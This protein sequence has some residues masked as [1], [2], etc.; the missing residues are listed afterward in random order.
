VLVRGE[1]VQDLLARDTG[2]ST[3]FTHADNDRRNTDG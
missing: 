3:S 1:T 2:I